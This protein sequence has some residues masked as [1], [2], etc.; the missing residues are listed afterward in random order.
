MKTSFF[1]A[2]RFS[3]LVSHL[4]SLQSLAAVISPSAVEVIFSY[5]A[6]F[7][8]TQER[9]A[10]DLANTHAQHLFG[11]LQSPAL[12]KSFGI[13]RN[14][15]GIG[16]PRLPMTYEILSN[17]KRAG[18][19]NVTYK[20]ASQMLL[21]ADAAQALLQ[22]RS[23][24]I[25]LPTD[26]DSFYSAEC[27]DVHYSGVS[28]FWYF[29][30]PFRP[31]CEFLQESP[32]ATQVEI[33]F[34]RTKAPAE[35]ISA[36]FDR[37]RSDNGNGELF[38]ITTVNGYADGYQD[39][40]DEGRQSFEEINE[41]LRLLGFEEAILSSHK[42]RP[43]HQFTKQV[44]KADGDLIEIRV[45]RLLAETASTSTNVTF[46]KFFK[47][48]LETADVII[49]AG[50]SGLGG[51]LDLDNLQQKA[52]AFE[53]D[54]EKKQLF[55]FDGCSTYSYYLSMFEQEKTKGQ[56]DIMTNGLTSYFAQQSPIQKALFRHLFKVNTDPT[57]SEVLQDMEKPLRGAS[58]LI[59][60]GSL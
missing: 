19:R 12:V 13:S 27:T 46:A 50:H 59:N 51:N 20:V 40:A 24:T 47:A 17:K 4:V 53:F 34:R 60:V 55:F 42:N 30:D 18:V 36:Q 14:T 45:T 8:S 26:L 43:I 11:Y 49:Y 35:D 58:Y 33:R 6:S 41:W 57:W 52:G 32:Q 28:D 31:G 44:K 23:W 21:H 5:Q 9:T 39:Q 3:L 56:I 48:A 15:P 7:Q 37:L 29:Y 22:N 1:F 54:Q 16:A 25:T 2:L 38:Q 10:L